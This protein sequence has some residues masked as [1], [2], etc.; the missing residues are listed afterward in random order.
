MGVDHLT[1]H[2]GSQA[3]MCGVMMHGFG[4]LLAAALT[5]ANEHLQQP[6]QARSLAEGGWEN[7]GTRMT[8]DSNTATLS[9]EARACSRSQRLYTGSVA[10]G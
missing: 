6:N 3:N 9:P 1:I 5:F 7:I 4:T 8:G 2:E 10:V